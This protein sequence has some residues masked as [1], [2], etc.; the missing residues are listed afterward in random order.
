MSVRPSSTETDRLEDLLAASPSPFSD[1]VLPNAFRETP[2]V[3]S[4]HAGARQQCLA[5]VRDAR[6]TARTSLQVITGDAGE[7][8]T[9]LLAWLRRQSEEGWRKGTATGRFALTVIPPLRSLARARHHVLQELV[10]Q[11]SVRLAGDRHIDEATDTPIEILLWRALLAIAKVLV[12]NKS[13][14]AELRARLEEATSANPDRYLSSCVEQLKH[15][16]PLVERAFVDTALRLPELAAVDREVFRIV[17]RFPEGGEAERTAIVDWL[18]GSS[19]SSERLDALGTSLV[20]DE[21][22]EAVRALKTLLALA[23][24]AGTPVLLAFDQIEGTVRLGPDAV[25]TFLETIAELY[26]DA[27]STVILVLCQTQLWPSLREQAPG[28]VKDRFDDTPAVHLKGLTPN[29]AL[30]LVETRMKHFWEGL[31]EHP[32]DPLFPLSREQVLDVVTREK[33]RTPRAVVR[34]FQALLREPR[35][36]R[37]TDV[38]K[39]PPP[40]Q[41]LDIVRRKL[42][43]LI[44]EE[45][46]TA[47]QPDA[48]A[49][50]A[51]AVAYD[52]FRQAQGAKRPIQ[53]TLVEEIAPHRARRTSIEGMRVVLQRNGERK[54][55]YIESSNSQNG[56]SAAS[57]VRRLAD[58][59]AANQADMAMLLREESFP[60][61]SAAHK[62]LLE[63]TS[64]GVV[65]R[66]AEG[67]IVPLAAIEALL[68]AAAAGDVPVDRKTA[69]DI[70]VEHLASLLAIP[71]RVVGKVFPVEQPRPR[72]PEGAKASDTQVTAILRHLQT[73]RAFE[74]AARLAATLGLSVETVDAALHVLAGRGAVDVVAD[75][76]RSP[77]VLL[78]PGASPS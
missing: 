46:R 21:E 58:V 50:L 53:G 22:A 73:E 61:P 74:P 16:W 41:P 71:A 78:R 1:A 15:G 67:E 66:I 45:P 9:H 37:N 11:L 13:T 27:P 69:L 30:L 55:V 2:D 24:F 5:L 34:Y 12:A 8:K 40:P 54:R 19:L 32:S 7:G 17:A 65:L 70:A 43:T 72:A 42:D 38:F 4:I 3:P 6:E 68:N 35:G 57:T 75:R 52:I 48:R 23:R 77:V 14:P 10:R 63:M 59:V 76:N 56:K 26:N 20:L 51:Q 29:E 64:R 31:D 39:P 18:G 44:D 25:M 36:Q 47:R 28:Y 60:L 62:T 49:A 33:L